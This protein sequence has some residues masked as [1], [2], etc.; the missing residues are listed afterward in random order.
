MRKE[1]KRKRFDGLGIGQRQ[2][3]LK[4]R[5]VSALFLPMKL[6]DSWKQARPESAGVPSSAAG[7]GAGAGSPLPLS[8]LLI[9][10]R[11]IG[12]EEGEEGDWERS[13]R[14]RYESTRNYTYAQGMHS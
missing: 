4:R 10:V 9:Q 12:G 7:A 6:S 14:P 3:G 8:I 1:G 11:D 2:K 5:R 13:W